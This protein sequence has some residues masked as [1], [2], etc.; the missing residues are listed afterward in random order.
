VTLNYTTS[1]SNPN[2]VTTSSTNTNSDLYVDYQNNVGYIG[3]DNGILYHINNLFGGT[4]TVDFCTVASALPLGSPVYDS[5]SVQVFV[6]DP[7]TLYSYTVGSS[8]FTNLAS[9]G[10]GAGGASQTSGPML[11]SFD[12]YVY[13]FSADDTNHHTSMTQLPISMASAAVVSLGP[14]STAAYPILY[15]GA[16][17]NNYFNNGPSSSS[18]IYTCGADPTNPLAQDLY[19]IGFTAGPTNPSLVMTAN[20]N[21]NTSHDTGTCSPITEFYDGT[22]DRIFVGMGDPNYVENG[23]DG[24]DIVTMWDVTTQLTDPTT[25][26]T[27]TSAADYF[28]GTTGFPIDNNAI[29]TAQA[30]SIYFSTLAPIPSTDTFRCFANH[31]CAVKL[32]QSGL[33]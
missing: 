32:T 4:P 33:Q 20:P 29:G 11:D 13:M 3:A 30:E 8:S 19:A 10:Y 23:D 16:F 5:E 2:C 25:T 22:T 31:F 17:D 1:T 12:G 28:G 24:A 26:P 18:T 7:L 6:S 21:V 9:Y 14:A 15:L 27:A